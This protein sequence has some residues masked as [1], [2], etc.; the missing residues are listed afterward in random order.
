MW[1]KLAQRLRNAKVLS[2][3]SHND[4][5]LDVGCGDGYMLIKS[6]AK[7]KLGITR[8]AETYLPKLGSTYTRITLVAVAE[9]INDA[10]LVI[11]ECLRVLAPYGKL[12]I[13]APTL[14]GD[15][16]SPL[17]SLHDAIEHK[18]LVTLGYLRGI[19]PDDYQITRKYFECGLNQLFVIERKRS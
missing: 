4:T 3:L 15:L 6:P 16:L 9:H 1:Y 10:E 11:T 19:I 13:T 17:V 12:L 7:Y 2:F 18:R 8:D 5:H 14:L